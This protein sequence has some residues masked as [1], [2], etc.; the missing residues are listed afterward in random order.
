VKR[1]LPVL[2][3][4]L[5]LQL[6]VAAFPDTRADLL[7]Y[8]Q[9]TRSLV[10]HGLVASYWPDQGSLAESPY[11]H[12]SIDYPPV[13]PYLLWLLGHALSVLDPNA[14]ARGGRGLDFFLRVPLVLAN[15]LIG[16]VLFSALRVRGGARVALGA[17][18][19]FLLSPVILFD[20]AYW[21][22]AD[23]VCALFVVAGLALAP[24]HP[25]WGCAALATGA[26]VKPFGY[27]FI[28]F[29]LAETVK[30]HGW[31]R[32]ATALLAAA[33][34]WGALL[35]PFAVAGRL[36]DIA[37]VL[38]LQLD[39]MPYA[40][41]NAHN[42]WWIVTRGVPW[43]LASE[44][45]LGPVTYEGLGLLLFGVF[46]LA[47][48]VGLL[49][50]RDDRALP[51]AGASV[52]FGLFALATHMH[53]NHLFLFLPLLLLARG[54]ERPWRRFFVAVSA[55]ALINM[56]LHDPFLMSRIDAHAPGPRVKLPPQLEPAPGFADYLR[57]EGYPEVADEMA[58]DSSVLRLA[59]TL[60]N[61]EACVLLFAW[62]VWASVLAR[63]SIDP[64]AA[65]TPRL[66]PWA[67]AAVVLFL[68]AAAVPFLT[69][70]VRA[71]GKGG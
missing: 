30:R 24:G 42:L 51:M 71:A 5:A 2:A 61:S 16:A 62:W 4:S 56:F 25:E 37:A 33:A 13:L 53:E 46:A 35:V 26:L 7:A 48:F 58:G 65:P 1:L 50:S 17:A 6:L 38:W 57:R 43:V 55:V 20:T 39:A 64:I 22:Q 3:A 21:G 66:P 45:A 8:R 14:L 59:L 12:P 40:S 32:G 67:L 41:V 36:R 31:R 9:W 49:R 44:R 63:G 29:A 28:P 18:A 10:A 68:V 34:V 52:A 54:E 15:G 60:V 11:E 47:A 27:A 23:S 70:L 19:L 69:K